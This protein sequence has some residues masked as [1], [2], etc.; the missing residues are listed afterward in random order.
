[1]SASESPLPTSRTLSRNGSRSERVALR[2]SSRIAWACSKGCR[3]AFRWLLGSRQ[4]MSP[5]VQLT[6]GLIALL[7]AFSAKTD[8]DGVLVSTNEKSNGG[9][10]SLKVSKFD[11][12]S[13]T[14]RVTRWREWVNKLR[15]GFGSAYPLL[16]NQTSESLD[17][18][19]YWWGLT[20]NALLDFDNFNQEQ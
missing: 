1:M 20:W 10:H 15:Y 5:G 12:S 19:K 14:S 18:L 17:P 8:G 2:S 13:T 4:V 9:F 16:A 6:H 7:R 11:H 3:P